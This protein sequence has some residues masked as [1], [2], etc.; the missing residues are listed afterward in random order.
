[1]ENT[2]LTLSLKVFSILDMNNNDRNSRTL[3]VCFVIAVMSL[4]SLKFVDVGQRI[5]SVSTTQVL[6]ETI[7]QVEQVEPFEQVEEVEVILPNGEVEEEVLNAN[8]I[9]R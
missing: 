1:M 4:V 7:E 3:I 8:Y 6:G 2:A 9:G 5:E